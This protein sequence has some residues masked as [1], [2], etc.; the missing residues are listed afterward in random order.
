MDISPIIKE[1]API[2]LAEIKKAKSVLLHCHPSPDPDSVCSV[3]AMKS[4]IEQLGICATIIRGDSEI[5]SDGFA[6]FPGIDLIVDKSFGE[7]D[8]KEFDLFIIL[9][10]GSPSMI[11][12]INTPVFPMAIK[13]IVID[14]HKSNQLYADINLVDMCS[15]T[16]FVL[17]QLFT[18]WN[19]KLTKDIALNLF[20]GMYTDSGG[21]KYAPIDYKVFEAAAILTKIA[22]NFVDTIFYIENTRSKE[23]LY[24]E[25]I[26]LSSM[27]TFLGDN[28]AMASVSFKQLEEKHIPHDDLHSDIPNQLKSVVGCN[29]GMIL[30]E[31]EPR[32]IKVSMRSRDVEKFDVS[33]LAV[34]FGGGGHRAAAGIRFVDMSLEDVKKV[35]VAKAKELYNL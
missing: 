33:K 18:L 11:S 12:Y 27:E 29:I 24:F 22:P 25:A 19:I 20:I 6:C 23:S 8:L 21:F 4:A 31:R 15:S 26:A 1:K 13:T 9:D 2:I 34:A 32:Q 7:V 17:F 10:S 30:V 16:A 5:I 14:H 35:I 3:L 28:I